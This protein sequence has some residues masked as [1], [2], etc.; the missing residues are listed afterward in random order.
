MR[1]LTPPKVLAID[2]EE[3]M[4]YLI[5][6]IGGSM[7]FEVDWV[8]DGEAALEHL[9]KEEYDVILSD[10]QLPRMPGDQFYKEVARRNPEMLQRLIFMTGDA[11]N[12][13]TMNFLAQSRIPYLIKPFDINELHRV[14]KRLSSELPA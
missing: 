9:K 10:F 13:R 2:D 3:V 12:Q 6:R 4:G 7:G 1:H 5:Q 11:L 8:S 14:I